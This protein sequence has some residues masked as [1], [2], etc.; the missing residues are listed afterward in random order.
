MPE[1][2]TLIAHDGG[3]EVRTEHPDCL[4]I[5]PSLVTQP[6]HTAVRLARYE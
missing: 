4:L 2:G 1:A 6:G 3:R 5:L